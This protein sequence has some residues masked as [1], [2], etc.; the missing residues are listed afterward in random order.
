MQSKLP[1]KIKVP[2]DRAFWPAL[3]WSEIQSRSGSPRNLKNHTRN[4]SKMFTKNPRRRIKRNFLKRRKR[5]LGAAVPRPRVPRKPPRTRTK[6]QRRPRTRLP[7]LFVIWTDFLID[8]CIWLWS[9]PSQKWG[10]RSRVVRCN[11]ANLYARFIQFCLMMKI[12]VEFEIRRLLENWR[13]TVG[14]TCLSGLWETHP[15]GIYRFPPPRKQQIMP[16]Q[17]YF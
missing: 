9:S 14:A 4:C 16:V 17:R 11:L 13:K 15:W 3:F 2:R 6:N 12:L 7:L 5:R 1:V 8:L 10:G